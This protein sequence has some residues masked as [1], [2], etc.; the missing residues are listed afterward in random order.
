MDPT[1]FTSTR[2]YPRLYKY[3]IV[4]VDNCPPSSYVAMFASNL[5]HECC[6]ALQMQFWLFQKS[7]RGCWQH[8]GEGYEEV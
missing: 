5:L 4:F 1:C 8:V 3:K 2:Q 7:P 6:M